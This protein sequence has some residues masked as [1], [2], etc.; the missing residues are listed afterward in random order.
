MSRFLI[1]KEDGTYLEQIESMY[2]CRWKVNEV[3]CNEKS[4]YIADYPPNY[5]C[6]N[7]GFCKCFEKEDGKIGG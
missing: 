5:I 2:L 3:C 7:E 4:R 6:E 1:K